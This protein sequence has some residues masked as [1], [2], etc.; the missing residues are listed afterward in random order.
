MKKMMLS[1]C[2]I[3]MAGNAV[4]SDG[5]IHF[6]GT[7]SDQTCNVDST[8]QDLNVMLGTVSQS[9]FAG[10]AGTSAAPTKFTLSLTGCPDT[11]TGA[12]VKFDGTPDAVNPHLLALDSETGSATGV[13]IEIADKNGAEIP[14][15]T[16]SSDYALE[17]G[18]NTLDFIA[19]YVSTA[20]SVGPGKADAT[21]QFTINYK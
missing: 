6:T 2:F 20:A 16:A 21:S 15:Q 11:I 4:A 19:R 7:I 5:T 12:N 10:I 14:L 18:A 1:V 3:L 9:T 8:A 13:G 17:E